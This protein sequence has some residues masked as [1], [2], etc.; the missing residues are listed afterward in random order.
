M[1]ALNIRYTLRAKLASLE[2]RGEEKDFHDIRFL[3]MSFPEE[4]N[5]IADSLDEDGRRGFIN[6][7]GFSEFSDEERIAIARVLRLV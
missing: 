1:W 3:T 4:V 5:E 6:N 2:G 7:E